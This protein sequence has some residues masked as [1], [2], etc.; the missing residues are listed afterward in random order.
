MSNT[1]NKKRTKVDTDSNIDITKIQTKKV[2]LEYKQEKKR[3][4]EHIIST[5]NTN[6]QLKK[7]KYET[8]CLPERQQDRNILNI[9]TKENRLRRRNIN[10]QK[11]LAY[12]SIPYSMVH[13]SPDYIQ[14]LKNSYPQRSYYG[15]ASN[16]CKYC[17]AIFWFEERIR[18]QRNRDKNIIYTQCCKEGKIKIPPFKVPPEPLC[19]L[20]NYNGDSR[21]KHFLEKIR[22]Y[23]SLFCFTSMGGNID[24]C[25]NQGDGPHVFRVSGQIHHRIGSLVPQ[26]N[27]DPKFVQLYIYDTQNEINNRLQAITHE[28]SEN[29]ELDLGIIEGLKEM[30]DKYNPLVETFRKARDLLQQYNGIDVNVRII[31]AHKGDPI[32]YEMPTADELALLIVGD[33]ST[34]TVNVIL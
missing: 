28:D 24:K 19:T 2:K 4:S 8:I 26:P 23:N 31:G 13:F 9:D 11:K 6:K 5:S 18:H 17:G 21:S 1:N 25:I 30:L 3:N 34:E 10:L 16:Q 33:Y 14:Y 12:L 20:L 15:V 7:M 29:T 22:Q 27:N 32:Q